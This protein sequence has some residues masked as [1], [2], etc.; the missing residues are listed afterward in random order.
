MRLSQKE[1]DII[2]KQS[3]KVFGDAMVYIFGSRVEEHKQGGDIDIYIDTKASTNLFGK[4]LRLKTT[5]EDMLYKPVDIIV[6]T[7]KKRAIE[8]EACRNGVLI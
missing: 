5:L 3:K 4:K 2:K 8:Q 7:N 6:S 1:I